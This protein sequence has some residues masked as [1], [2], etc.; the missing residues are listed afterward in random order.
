MTP[1]VRIAAVACLLLAVSFCAA[2][3]VISLRQ[4]KLPPRESQA[5]AA[6]FRYAMLA[7]VLAGAVQSPDSLPGGQQRLAPAKGRHRGRRA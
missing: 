4:Q 7:G 1:V 6:R 3:V 5:S 2:G